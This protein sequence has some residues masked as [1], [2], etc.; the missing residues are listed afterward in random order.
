M[1]QN[2]LQNLLSK[3]TY[4]LGIV[5]AN[6]VVCTANLMGWELAKPT[7]TTRW[8]SLWSSA[9]SWWSSR[10]APS[11]CSGC[12][13]HS[14]LSLPVNCLHGPR[15]LYPPLSRWA[16]KTRSLKEF[17]QYVV[18]LLHRS[19]ALCA[20]HYRQVVF[21]LFWKRFITNIDVNIYFHFL[22]RH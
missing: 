5:T 21:V 16:C 13:L 20:W 19:P 15:S 3:E 12:A 4:K 1:I 14:F 6:D 22:D 9:A 18:W 8:W 7:R 11:V 2:L 10:C 17:P